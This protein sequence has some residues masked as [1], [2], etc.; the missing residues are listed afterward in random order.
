MDMNISGNPFTS[1]NKADRQITGRD[2]TRISYCRLIR[3]A[4]F[5][6]VFLTANMSVAQTSSGTISGGVVDTS[7]GVVVNAAIRL[8]NELTGDIVNA[9]VQLDGDFVFPDAGAIVIQTAHPIAGFEKNLLLECLEFYD[10][11]VGV[12][13]RQCVADNLPLQNLRMN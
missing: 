10:G 13:A 2:K 4:V 8:I 5:A 9:K 11:E 7:G 12:D 3:D 1:D 6:L